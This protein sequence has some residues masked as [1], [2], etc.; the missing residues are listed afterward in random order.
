MRLFRFKNKDHNEIVVM[1][2]N[3]EEAKRI[4]DDFIKDYP[5]G[6]KAKELTLY[7]IGKIEPSIVVS[8]IPPF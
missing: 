5:I 1:A 4:A 8:N 6:W 2:N 3:M 7:N